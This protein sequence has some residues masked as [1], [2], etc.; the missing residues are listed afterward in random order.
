[1]NRLIKLGFVVALLISSLSCF[2]DDEYSDFYFSV[3]AGGASVDPLPN[4]GFALEANVGYNFNQYFAL[5]VQGNTMPSVQWQNNLLNTYN[6]FNLAAKGTVPLGNF[7][8]IYGKLG[9]GIGVSDWSGGSQG[10]DDNNLYPDGDQDCSSGLYVCDGSAI[11]PV[12]LGTVGVNFKV[13]D[14]LSIYA[15]NNNFIPLG[16]PVGR[17]GYTVNGM[18]GIQ[19]LFKSNNIASSISSRADNCLTNPYSPECSVVIK[20]ESPVI[21]QAKPQPAIVKE[22]V[23]KHKTCADDPSQPDCNV[24]VQ[25]SAVD[26]KHNFKYPYPA[27]NSR[28]QVPQNEDRYTPTQNRDTSSGISRQSGIDEEV[29]KLMNNIHGNKIILGKRLYLLKR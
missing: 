21:Q 20:I 18:L 4:A 29:L 14:T 22:V 8:S 23:V 13:S 7:F 10:V 1:M 24:I 27:F 9:A 17:F 11:S 5:E 6:V 25:V 3:G 12:F 15:E 16:G 2:A 19:Y 26:S 28:V